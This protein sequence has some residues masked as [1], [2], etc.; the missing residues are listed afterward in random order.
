[1]DGLA[2]RLADGTHGIPFGVTTATLCASGK[3]NHD[4]AGQVIG[5]SRQRCNH[6]RVDLNL[7]V[8]ASSVQLLVEL[9]AERGMTPSDCLHGSWVPGAALTD[10]LAELPPR[11]EIAVMRNLLRRCTDEPDLGIEAGCRYHVAMH[12]VWGLAL[13]T[14]RTLRET[15]DVALRYPELAW[16]FTTMD[17]DVHDEL[18]RLRVSGSNIPQDVRAFLVERV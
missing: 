13:L 17:F 18:A 3:T 15:V 11:Q 5:I 6:S 14:S 9:G 16:A 1:S 2:L 10:P 8:S 4:F 7:P 12:G